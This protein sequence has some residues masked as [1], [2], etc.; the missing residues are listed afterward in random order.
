MRI[1]F[2]IFL[3]FLTFMLG[4]S[5]S[6]FSQTEY[7][8]YRSSTNPLYWKNRKPFEGYW[9][10]D[11]HYNIKASLNDSSDIISGN[12]ELIYWNNS[13]Y[14]ISH[15]YFHLYSNA[16]TKDSYLADLYKNNDY[17]LKFGKYRGKDLGT[18]VNKIT[19]N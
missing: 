2:N 11:V 7:I 14:D 6:I 1:H 17:N 5:Y 8:D 18:E 3:L 16:Q 15:V 19:I 9:Q 13:P 12:E 10:Q 4:N